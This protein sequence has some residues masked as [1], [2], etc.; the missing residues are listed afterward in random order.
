MQRLS[1]ILNYAAAVSEGIAMEVFYYLFSKKMRKMLTAA[2]LDLQQLQEI[3]LRIGQPVFLYYRGKEY[4]LT[5]EGR[6]DCDTAAGYRVQEEELKEMLESLSGYSLYAFEE[7]LKAGYLTVPGGHRIG[8]AGKIVQENG[9]VSCIRNIAFLNIR[10]AHQVKGCADPVM[11]YLYQD[12]EVCHTLIISPPRCGKTTLLRDMI[13]QISNGYGTV[14]GKTVGV[15]DERGEL[16]GSYC[17]IPQNDLGIRTDVLEGCTKGNGMMMLLRSMAPQVL[18]VDELGSS[19]DGEAVEQLFHC[20]CR[21][22]A[23][24]HGKALEDLERIPLLRQMQKQRC[25]E[26]YIVLD[27][28]TNPG[29]VKEISDGNGTILYRRDSI[30]SFG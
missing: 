20:G 3:R 30:C 25:F 26:R 8:V 2:Q 23:T 7:E 19:A 22:L 27:A 24:V 6:L 17:G 21:L 13:R 12:D 9:R 15:V 1:H 16:A 28:Q 18:A 14:S 11:D 10:L 29:I 4:V 5:E